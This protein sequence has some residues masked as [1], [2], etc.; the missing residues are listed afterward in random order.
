M[1]SRLDETVRRTPASLSKANQ[2]LGLLAWVLVAAV[3]LVAV[4][5]ARV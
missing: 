4:S 1:V 2:A 3:S 5:V